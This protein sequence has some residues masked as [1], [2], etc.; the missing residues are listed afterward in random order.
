[1]T[2]Q[3]EMGR[4]ILEAQP[5]SREVGV[6]L[7]RFEAGRVELRLVLEP[8]HMQHH[9]I[10]HGGV[11][12]TLADMAIAF[13]G[14]SQLGNVVTLEFK[15]NLIRPGRG[16]AMVARGEVLSLGRR[17]AVCRAEIHAVENGEERLC[18][19]AQGTMA[20]VE[21]AAGMPETVET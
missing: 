21:G 3:L 6:E 16:E 10:V 14:G 8:R 4:R 1:M 5:F 13:A 11:T 9:G 12:A 2:D 20:K 19:A 17:Q 15:L 18:A 7:T